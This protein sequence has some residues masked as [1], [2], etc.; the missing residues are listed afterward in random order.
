MHY[1]RGAAPGQSRLQ[2][3]LRD[4]YLYK[5]RQVYNVDIVGV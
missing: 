3:R 2:E 4:G 1:G 5:S